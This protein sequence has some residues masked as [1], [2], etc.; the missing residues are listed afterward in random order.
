[1]DLKITHGKGNAR[2]SE[3]AFV[4]LKDGSTLF[5]YTKYRGCW[6]DHAVADLAQIIYSPKT[7]TWSKTYFSSK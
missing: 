1:M 6:D 4:D 3:G 2:N 5:I 7:K